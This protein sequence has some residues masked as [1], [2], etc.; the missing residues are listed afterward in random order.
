LKEQLTVVPAQS[1]DPVKD[2]LA[3]NR[4]FF[5]IFQMVTNKVIS[6]DAKLALDV[7]LEVSSEQCT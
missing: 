4:W 2:K 3:L 7:F 5:K 1:K 6:V